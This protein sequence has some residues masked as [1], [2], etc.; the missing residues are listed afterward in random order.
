MT[1]RF[2]LGVLAALMLL[3]AVLAG[4]GSQKVSTPKEERVVTDTTGREVHLPGEVKSIAVVPIPW[5]S[6]AFAVR[7]FGRPHYGH[8][9]VGE[10]IV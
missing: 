4:C 3:C 6:V 10:G 9:P 1:H 8:A 7:R 2:S 5:A